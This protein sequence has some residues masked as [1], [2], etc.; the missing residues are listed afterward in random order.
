MAAAIAQQLCPFFWFFLATTAFYH[1]IQRPTGQLR[2]AFT[3]AH[4]FSVA[5]CLCQFSVTPAIPF[6]RAW[7]HSCLVFGLHTALLL[8]LEKRSVNKR[9]ASSLNQRLRAVFLVWGDLRRLSSPPRPRHRE[10]ATAHAGSFPFQKARRYMYASRIV[11]LLCAQCAAST[12]RMWV[13]RTLQINMWDY[14][15]EKQ[16]LWPP[17]L[18]PRDF[19]WRAWASVFW[20]WETQL[21]LS[22]AHNILAVFFVSVLGWSSADEWPPLFGSI[23]EA[24]SLRRFWGVYWHRLSTSVAQVYFDQLLVRRS[25]GWAAPKGIGRA[26]RACWVFSFSALCHAAANW[27][28]VGRANA[29]QELRFFFVNFLVCWVETRLSSGV[30]GMDSAHTSG[31]APGLRCA[32]GYSRVFLVFFVF[33]PAWQWSLFSSML[34]WK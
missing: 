25:V 16:A 20:V 30:A 31:W 15:P 26:L 4:I 33:A 17:T 6:R 23:A 19:C 1:A 29:A 18:A 9:D 12:A 27:I 7:V 8:V 32:L 10:S 3:I 2:Y 11:A 34:G 14:A 28:V 13:V 24:A 22:I 5:L 21:I